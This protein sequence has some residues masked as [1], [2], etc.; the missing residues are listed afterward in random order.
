MTGGTGLI[1]NADS[2]LR[3][4][5]LVEGANPFAHANN[6]NLLRCFP[7][8]A[9]RLTSIS[10]TNL[11]DDVQSNKADQS[12]RSRVTWMRL[13]TPRV[14]DAVALPMAQRPVVL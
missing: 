12:L 14:G 3:R 4:E 13:L 1:L 9:L 10:W 8:P 2:M 11:E 5:Y 7:N 6:V